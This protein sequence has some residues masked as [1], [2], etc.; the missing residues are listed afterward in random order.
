MSEITPDGDRLSAIYGQRFSS[1]DLRKKEDLWQTLCQHFFQDFV[2]RD[3]TV[4]DLGAG[5]CEFVN[6]IVAAQKIA[7]DLNPD[8]ARFADDDVRVVQTDSRDLSA[9]ASES[10]DTVFSSNFFEHLSDSQALLDTL[11]ECRRVLRPH[12]RVVVLMPNIRAIPGAYWDYLDH[13]LPLTEHSLCEAL[14]LCGFAPTRVEG[15]F[16]P[17]TVRNSRLP[18]H[19][20]LIR[21]Y[22]KVK[23]AW[24]LIG[25]KMLVVAVKREQGPDSPPRDPI[26]H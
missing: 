26:R 20:W 16:L 8:T 14:G 23:P 21:T 13:H 5:Y 7:V 4:L 24:R 15:R 11:H 19:P 17:Y 3:G 18:V 1:A 25:K 2:P 22:L 10:I 6:N 9:I 12:G